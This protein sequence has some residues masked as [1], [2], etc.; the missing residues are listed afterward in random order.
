MDDGAIS[1][2]DHATGADKCPV[3]YCRFSLK[4]GK[5]KLSLLLPNNQQLQV[6]ELVKQALEASLAVPPEESAASYT[7]G[8]GPTSPGKPAWLVASPLFRSVEGRAI[9]ATTAVLKQALDLQAVKVSLLRLQHDCATMSGLVAHRITSP[10]SLSSF[11]SGTPVG[12]QASAADNAVVTPA[13]RA[14]VRRLLISKQC[15]DASGVDTYLLTSEDLCRWLSDAMQSISAE[16]RAQAATAMEAATWE[17]LEFQ[18]ALVDIENQVRCA[19]VRDAQLLPAVVCKL[20]RMVSLFE[21]FGLHRCGNSTWIRTASCSD[22][23]SAS[24][25]MLWTRQWACYR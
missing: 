18:K 13:I 20:S 25:R 8:A 9:E 2:G 21:C 23:P 6:D 15:C 5:L 11:N 24:T 22:M 3:R 19:A 4:R 14:L 7:P 16:G 12:E 17:R 1:S 10:D